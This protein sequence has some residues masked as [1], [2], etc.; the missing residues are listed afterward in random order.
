MAKQRQ[1]QQLDGS[2]SNNKMSTDVYVC[3]DMQFIFVL[4]LG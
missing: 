4:G 2:S 1:Q 3:K